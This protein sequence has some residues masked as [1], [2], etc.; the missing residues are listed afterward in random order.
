MQMCKPSWL[1]K[2]IFTA[3]CYFSRAFIQWKSLK[4]TFCLTVLPDLLC[5]CPEGD[6]G[7]FQVEQSPRL[8]AEV[9]PVEAGQG[10]VIAV[11]AH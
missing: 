7:L 1:L 10:H 11:E 2:D 3:D 8:G 6:V 9:G 5:L 4:R